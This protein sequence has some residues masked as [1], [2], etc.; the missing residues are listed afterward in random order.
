[1]N[2]FLYCRKSTD[3]EDKQILSIEAQLSELRDFAKREGVAIIETFIEKQSAKIPGRPIFNK[4]VEQIE[5]G[6]AQGVIAWHPD[7]LA[8]NS[9]DGGKIIYLVDT[10]TIAA[11]RFPTFWFEPTP[12]GKFMLNI[13]FG[14][15]KYYIDSLS[16]NTKRDLRQKLRRGEYPG[17]VPVGYINDSRDKSVAVDRKKAKIIKEAFELYAK[18]E[19]RLEDIS[20]FLAQ[21]GIVTRGTKRGVKRSQVSHILL[22][23]FYYGHF[24]FL[25][26]IH[27]GKHEPIITKK[28]FDKVQEV[29]RDRGKPQRKA[30]DPKPLCGL[31]H[32]GNCGMGITAEVRKG[33]TY[34]RCTKKSKTVK[35]LE[36][37]IREEELDRQLSQELQ[38]FSLPE[39]WASRLL[40]MTVKEEQGLALSSAVL[41]QASRDE[42]QDIKTKLPRL[43]DSYLD[44]DIDRDDYRQKKADLMSR[45]KTLEEKIGDLEQGRNSWLGP[46]REWLNEAQNIGKIAQNSDLSAKKVSAKKIF[47]SGMKLCTQKITGRPAIQWAAV[48]AGKILEPRK[49][50]CYTMERVKGIEPSFRPWEGHVLPLY[51]TRERPSAQFPIINCQ[52]SNGLKIKT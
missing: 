23:P 26:E 11:L 48:A 39:D 42:L 19:S 21:N 52:F 43:L 14:Q 37:Y 3:V 28:L 4:M 31:L 34:Y 41:T 22:N 20:A 29:L 9:V 17:R 27:E 32:C 18:S 6:R 25:G 44:Q 33:H 24:R 1:M 5:K 36:K 49:G 50:I 7:R 15:S 30:N 47:G 38:K 35:C 16:E 46:M 45:K 10:G 8:R 2:Y 40:Q 13:S 51:D 12:Q